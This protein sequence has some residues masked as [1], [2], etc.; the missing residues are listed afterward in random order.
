MSNLAVPIG[1]AVLTCF[2]IAYGWILHKAV[3]QVVYKITEVRA[4]DSYLL[5]WVFGLLTAF[6][7]PM[8]LYIAFGFNEFADTPEGVKLLQQLHWA[9]RFQVLGL[10]LYGVAV[11]MIVPQVPM[12]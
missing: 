10:C 11:L 1:V 2:G 8:T 6:V 5:S 3:D 9:G 12:K 4:L 7:A